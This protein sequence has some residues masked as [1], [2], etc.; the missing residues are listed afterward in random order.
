MVGEEADGLQLVVAEEV[1]LL[2]DHDGGASALGVFG[3][4][5]VGGLWGQGGVMGQ[6]LPAEGGDDA[7]V[8]A[9]H[10]DGG[11]GQVD[12]GVAAAVQGW[13]AR[14]ARRR[15]CRRRPRR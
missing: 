10:P 5:R 9:A 1:R 6:G 4:Q 3:G 12:D 11:V 15:S 2:D 8:D 14:R 7:V 13:P